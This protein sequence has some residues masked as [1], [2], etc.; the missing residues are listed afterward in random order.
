MCQSLGWSVLVR[1]DGLTY[2]LLG[3]TLSNIDNYTVVTAESTNT[4]LTPT[5]TILAARAGP[6]QVNLTFL[7]PIEVRIH[8]SVTSDVYI[9]ITSSPETGLSNPPHSLTWL[10]PQCPLTVQVMRC[11]CILMSAEV[12]AIVHQGPPFCLSFITEWNSGDGTRAIMGSTTSN[13]DVVFH[14]VTLQR[15]TTFNEVNDKAEWGTL[16]YVVQAVSR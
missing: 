7:N 6:M 14:S 9:C 11:R 2:S 4:V 5:Q 16:Y 15:Q 10:S 12:R 13:P 3:D 1:V 8:S